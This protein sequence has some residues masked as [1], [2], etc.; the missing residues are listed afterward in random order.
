M[1]KIAILII[2]VALLAMGASGAFAQ[3][4]SCLVTQQSTEETLPGITVTWDSSFLCENAPAEGTYTFAAT[5]AN[6]GG[7]AEVVV[8]NA[9][10]LTHTTPRPRGQTPQATADAAGL[11]ITV[12]PGESKTF[13]V[14]GTY[15]LVTTGEGQKANLHFRASGYGPM[16][17]PFHLGINVRLRGSGVIEPGDDDEPGEPPP[18]AP[19]PPPWT[20]GPPPWAGDAGGDDVDHG[21]PANLPG[22]PPWAGNDDEEN[23]A[24][25]PPWVPGPPPGAGR[26]GAKGG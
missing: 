6:A 15:T 1:R 3:Q 21:P 2:T 8:M 9:M 17:E 19:G 11:P 25:P 18:W 10:T 24:G 22:P 26:P 14:S 20:P 4:Q 12:A 13:N 7:S 16:V 5:I 23:G